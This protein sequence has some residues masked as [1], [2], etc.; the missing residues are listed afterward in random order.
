[1]ALVDID[2]AGHAAN[3]VGPGNGH[4]EADIEIG[5]V[6]GTRQVGLGDEALA[7]RHQK[8]TLVGVVDH[9]LVG[10]ED[11]IARPAL[12]QKVLVFATVLDHP[13]DEAVARIGWRVH[14]PAE[15]LR[16]LGEGRPRYL[17]GRR[18]E[19]G[20]HQESTTIQHD[21]SLL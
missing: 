20:S 11:Q 10:D 12:A 7:R 8:S 5:I 19:R 15:G 1:M 6:V 17:S 21:Q 14:I 2:V 4:A 18:H 16:N 3:Q 9:I 13:F